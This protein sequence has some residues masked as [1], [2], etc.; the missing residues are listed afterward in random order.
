[1]GKCRAS[2]SRRTAPFANNIYNL[3]R[4]YAGGPV[5]MSALAGIDIALWGLEGRRR[6]PEMRRVA[7]SAQVGFAAATPRRGRSRAATSACSPGR[8]SASRSTRPGSASCPGTRRPGRSPGFIG[9]GGEIRE[10]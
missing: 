10:R 4:Q 6:P 5:F 1:M 7:A 8:G 9:P 2:W 3:P